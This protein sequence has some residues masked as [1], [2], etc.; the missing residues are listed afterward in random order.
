MFARI[1]R[2]IGRQILISTHSPDLLRDDGIG[3]DEVLLLQPASEGTS[4]RTA[5]SFGEIKELLEGGLNLGD[6]V[7][8]LTRPKDVQQLTLFGE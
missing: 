8:P 6:A 5:S 2:R 3:L 1:Q 4:V 7:M